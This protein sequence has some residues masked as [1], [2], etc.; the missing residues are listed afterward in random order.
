MALTDLPNELLLGVVDHL[1]QHDLNVFS[2]TNRKLHDILGREL[3]KRDVR[4]DTNKALFWAAQWGSVP[5]LDPSLA[6]GANINAIADQT[7]YTALQYA[8][9]D[10]QVIMVALLL[11]KG[12]DPRTGGPGSSNERTKRPPLY[13][14]CANCNLRRVDIIVKAGVHPDEVPSALGNALFFGD[15]D[16]VRRLIHHGVDLEKWLWCVQGT[17]LNFVLRK[18]RYTSNKDLLQLLLDAGASVNSPDA[19]GEPPLMTWLSKASWPNE[20]VTLLIN[21]GANVDWK[22]REG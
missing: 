19:R 14:A 7:W 3:Y 20:T 1:T 8:C 12:A 5:T 2:R 17:P 4:T 11:A 9:S 10:N 16:V 15:L 18:Y 22:S 13:L 6:A 21:H